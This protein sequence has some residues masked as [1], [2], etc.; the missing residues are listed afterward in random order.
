ML[1]CRK[2]TRT[3]THIHT[4]THNWKQQETL[5]YFLRTTAAVVP[6]TSHPSQAATR[7]KHCWGCQHHWCCCCC[8]LP[9]VGKEDD[10]RTA[11]TPGLAVHSHHHEMHWKGKSRGFSWCIWSLWQNTQV[12]HSQTYEWANNKPCVLQ[13]WSTIKLSRT[14]RSD[15]ISCYGSRPKK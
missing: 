9:L 14:T 2:N 10:G 8:C 11:Q 7:G 4:H 3:H 13:P 15:P 1:I 6:H 12:V 5:P